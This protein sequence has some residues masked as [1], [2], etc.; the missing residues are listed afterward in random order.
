MTIQAPID[1]RKNSLRRRLFLA[2]ATLQIGCG[3]IFL[4]DI[5]MEW[6]GVRLHGVLEALAVIG[7][8]IGAS[9]TL[10]E[11]RHLLRR[12]TKVERELD[13]VSGAF[14]EVIEQHF[15][16]W[17]LTTAERDVA[18]LSIKGVPIADI[19]TMRATREGTIKAQSA[20]IYRKAGVSSRSELISTMVEELISGLQSPSIR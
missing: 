7:L 17:G 20:A 14:Q 16:R 6:E 11:Y 1:V 5:V 2:A 13:V 18:L 10:R 12:N 4:T 3:L 8:A 9:L 19:A 15:V